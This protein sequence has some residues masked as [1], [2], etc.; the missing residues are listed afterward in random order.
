MVDFILDYI[1]KGVID[2]KYIKSKSQLAD[3]FTKFFPG[4]FLWYHIDDK[5]QNYHTLS[6]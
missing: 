2:I 1:E 5:K 3:L 4:I 6:E